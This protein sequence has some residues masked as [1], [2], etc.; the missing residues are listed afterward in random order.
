MTNDRWV[1]RPRPNAQPRLKLLCFPYASG[2]ASVFHRWPEHLPADIEVAAVQLPGREERLEEEPY[3]DVRCLTDTLVDVL[4]RYLDRPFALFGHSVGALVAFETARAL[5]RRGKSLPRHLFV[6][7]RGA[8][9]RPHQL[10]SA[11]SS[12]DAALALQLRRL[13][14]TPRE[15]LDD[16]D[17]MSVVLPLFRADLALAE[18]YV[19]SPEEPLDCPISAF[20]ASFD[21]HARREDL[22][23]WSRETR[24]AFRLRMFPGGHFFIHPSRPRLLQAIAEDLS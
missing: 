11:S 16:P 5:R 14:G 8:P 24:A 3:R 20:G 17:F 23:S 13:G 4:E 1:I 10:P 2:G 19:Y 12:S 18:T 9:S 21:E 7:A 6:S 22:S 15:V